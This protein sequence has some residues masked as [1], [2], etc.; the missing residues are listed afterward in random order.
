MIDKAR[1][2]VIAAEYRQTKPDA[3]VFRIRCDGL[4]QVLVGSTLD[5]RSEQ[6]K[7]AWAKATG[8]PGALDRRFAGAIAEFGLDALTFET[9][10]VLEVTPSMTAAQVRADLATLED[11]WGEKLGRG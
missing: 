9:L 4:D 10:E 2:R 8:S 3:G 6:N 1:R 5:L 11:L 7:L